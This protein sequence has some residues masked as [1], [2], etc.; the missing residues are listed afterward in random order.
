MGPPTSVWANPVEVERAT[1]VTAE[2][3]NTTKVFIVELLVFPS[4]QVID[5]VMRVAIW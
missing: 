3:I 1:A 5:F 4:S 2:M